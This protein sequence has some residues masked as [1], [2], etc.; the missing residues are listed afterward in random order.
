M[1]S[2]RDFHPDGEIRSSIISKRRSS[3]GDGV[4]CSGDTTPTTTDSEQI[5]LVGAIKIKVE[6]TIQLSSRSS[7]CLEIESHV[8]F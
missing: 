4:V 1:T 5:I 7:T 8:G 2:G 3:S 6:R